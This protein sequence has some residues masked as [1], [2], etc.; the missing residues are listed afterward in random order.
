MQMDGRT[1]AKMCIQWLKERVEN[2][3]EFKIVLELE[4]LGFF[5]CVLLEALEYRLDSYEPDS[6]L[7]F[8][9]FCQRLQTL[10]G[11][12]MA[13]FAPAGGRDKKQTQI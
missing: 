4:L 11:E 6:R 9:F 10:L 1:A 7:I 2:N 8:K 13:A 12:N 5:R 3:R